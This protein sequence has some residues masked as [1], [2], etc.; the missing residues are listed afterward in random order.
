MLKDGFSSDTI[1]NN[2]IIFDTVFRY[3]Y[4]DSAG[5]ILI[6]DAIYKSNVTIIVSI[7]F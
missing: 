7:T 6:I 1:S 3:V 4:N 2:E 5:I